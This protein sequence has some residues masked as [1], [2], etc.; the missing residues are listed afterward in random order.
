MQCD[1]HIRKMVME[2][3]QIL[4]TTHRFLDGTAIATKTKK[5]RSI[6]IYEL[7][8]AREFL[9]KATHINH[10]CVKW[11]RES[12]D[13]Y[14]W[15]YQHFVALLAEFKFRYNHPHCYEKYIDIL[16][17][18]PNNMP[19]KQKTDFAQ[20]MPDQYKNKDIVVAY[21]NY[22]NGEKMGFA[23]WVKSRDQPL[24]IKN[25][26]IE[27]M[28][29]SSMVTAKEAGDNLIKLNKILQNHE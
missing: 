24:W 20:C 28:I 5:G 26:L 10:P 3:C 11:A 2:S 18:L 8:E 13:N 16:S 22:Y 1:A 14:N 7:N 19:S 12:S 29:R 27:K 6:T 23:K 25:Y 9:L 4:S 21:R 17:Q 15:L